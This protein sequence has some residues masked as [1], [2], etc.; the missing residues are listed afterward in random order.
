[1]QPAFSYFRG[2]PKHQHHVPENVEQ[3]NRHIPCGTVAPGKCR[4]RGSGE[5]VAHCWHMVHY[6]KKLQGVTV[7]WVSASEWLFFGQRYGRKIMKW[8]STLLLLVSVSHRDLN[9]QIDADTLEH[10]SV[11]LACKTSARTHSYDR[12]AEVISDICFDLKIPVEKVNGT[13]MGNELNFVRAF[14]QYG[15][16]SEAVEDDADHE[17]SA[18]T[19]SVSTLPCHI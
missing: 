19:H 16:L 2:L 8:E 13:V 11:A 9:F 1:M 5:S 6:H 15:M 3:A 10:R 4:P 14:K 18:V 7:H 17:F 12:T